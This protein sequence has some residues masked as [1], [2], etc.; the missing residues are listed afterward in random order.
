M[1]YIWEDMELLSGKHLVSLWDGECHSPMPFGA[2]YAV[3]MVA[4]K[5]WVIPGKP[6][7]TLELLSSW[8]PLIKRIFVCCISADGE[9]SHCIFHLLLRH[10]WNPLVIKLLPENS[11]TSYSYKEGIWIPD[12]KSPLL[13]FL[14]FWCIGGC[15]KLNSLTLSF[16]STSSIL[17]L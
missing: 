4:S 1:F 11:P 10:F 9:G 5:A 15:L 17:P 3:Y 14:Q 13:V 12:A 16:F 6:H 2:A 7:I 8:R